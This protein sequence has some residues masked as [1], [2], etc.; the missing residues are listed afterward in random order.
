MLRSRHHGSW[1]KMTSEG[2]QSSTECWFGVCTLVT[3][4]SECARAFTYKVNVELEYGSGGFC[5]LR[6]PHG[7]VLK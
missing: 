2:V 3:E 4:S 5:K 6:T 7:I 1:V